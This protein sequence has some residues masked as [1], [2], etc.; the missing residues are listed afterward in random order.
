MAD[1]PALAQLLLENGP[2]TLTLLPGL[3]GSVGALRH[4][5]EDVLR[6]LPPDA[7][8]SPLETAG[9]PLFPFSGRISDGSFTWQDRRVALQPNFLPETHA[10]HGQAWLSA[11]RVADSDASRA[12]LVFEYERGDWPWRYR[13]EQDFRLLEDG[14]E[15]TLSL[16]NESDELMP[17]GFGWH[18]YFPRQ[19]ARV[20]VAVDRIWKAET[21]M[22]PDQLAQPTPAEDLRDWRVV[23]QLDLDNAY[24]VATPDAEMEWPGRRLRVDMTS[25]PALGHVVVYAPPGRDFFCVEPVSHAPDAVNNKHPA[26]VTGL[27]TLSPGETLSA[28][29]SLKISAV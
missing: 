22:I 20:K 28:K 8:P 13:A 18:P 14:L 5:G 7:E 2:L 21:G 27:K 19:D 24:T 6:P 3:G 12:R 4:N 29:I 11:W 9:F 26:D 1:S 17:A 25:D 16:T 15:L 10:I 23:D